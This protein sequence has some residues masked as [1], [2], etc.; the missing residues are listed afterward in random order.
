MCLRIQLSSY[1][2]VTDNGRKG[3]YF[4]TPKKLFLVETHQTDSAT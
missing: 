2:C 1:D 4:F 3:K